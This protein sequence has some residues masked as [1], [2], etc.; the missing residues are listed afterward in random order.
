MDNQRIYSYSEF[1]LNLVKIAVDMNLEKAL[2]ILELSMPFTSSEL[3]Q[4]LRNKTKQHHP[5]KG[6]SHERMVEVNIAKSFLEPFVGK[7]KPSQQY[8]NK[9]ESHT[10]RSKSEPNFVIVGSGENAQL[11]IENSYVSGNH[12]KM[13]YNNG[14]WWIEDLGS[15]NGTFLQPDS[16]AWRSDPDFNTVKLTPGKKYTIYPGD[17]IYLSRHFS[18]TAEK[19][20][21]KATR[22]FKEAA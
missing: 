8:P 3:N 6:G 4:A 17:I 20:I 13:G 10:R 16:P 18:V 14:L 12:L 2:G 1:Y 21:S 11:Y 5:D 9:E 7:D 22:F 19:L 15:T